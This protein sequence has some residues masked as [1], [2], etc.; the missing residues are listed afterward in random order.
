MGHSKQHCLRGTAGAFSQNSP[1]SF[2][3]LAYEF[4]RKTGGRANQNLNN[5][6][7]NKAMYVIYISK[8]VSLY[9]LLELIMKYAN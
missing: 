9:A 4:Q 6:L 2:I 7:N 8:C 1:F 5:P 3:L